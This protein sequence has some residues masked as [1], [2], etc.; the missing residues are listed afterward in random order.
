MPILAHPLAARAA[1]NVMQ[2][3]VALASKLAQQGKSGALNPY[4][5]L[6][7]Y[8]RHTRELIIP[9]SVAPA[10]VVVY[11]PPAGEQRPAVHVNFHGGGFVL[12]Q[13]GSDDPLCRFLAAE[14]GVVV[15][16]VDY[17]VAPQH[18]FP[19]PA[20]QAYEVVRWIATHG[21]E[22]GW[23]G[24]RLSVGGQSAGGSLAAA[25][26]RQALELGGPPIALQVLHYAALDLLTPIRQKR[27]SIGRPRLHPW[28][29]DVF[30]S[31]YVQDRSLCADRLVSPANAK[32]VA[33]LTGIAPAVVITP[34]QDILHA[35]SKRYAERLERHGALVAY[36]ELPN[37]DHAYDMTDQALAGEVYASIAQHLK[38][39]L[40]TTK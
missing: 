26:A 7:Q 31:A 39:A 4:Q 30:D 11:T 8:P 25:V 28:L 24:S 15:V 20:R 37:V 22:E 10:P 35:E 2:R 34:E 13:H 23:D 40:T 1:A 33:D 27:S 36:H 16:D 32:D 29:C 21:A 5:R 3:A 18:P 12:P 6:R 14:A 17:A 38:R 19:G 9:T